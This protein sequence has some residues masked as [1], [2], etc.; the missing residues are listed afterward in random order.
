MRKVL[1][2][3]QTPLQRYQRNSE[4]FHLSGNPKQPLRARVLIQQWAHRLT[5]SE[6]EEMGEPPM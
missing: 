6:V 3:V 2:G 4:G 5:V 1:Q